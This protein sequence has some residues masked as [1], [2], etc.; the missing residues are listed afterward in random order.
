MTTRTHQKKA[1]EDRSDGALSLFKIGRL[2]CCHIS[3]RQVAIGRLRNPPNRPGTV[4]RQRKAHSRVS[5]IMNKGGDAPD[6][7]EV[8]E[9]GIAV[10]HAMR[11]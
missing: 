6:F 1:G 4:G 10:D 9:A 11:R 7:V 2:N 5:S 3:P 8:G